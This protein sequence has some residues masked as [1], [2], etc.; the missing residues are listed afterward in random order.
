MTL[1]LVGLAGQSAAADFF[2]A[3]ALSEL[4]RIE[5]DIDYEGPEDTPVYG[6]VLRGLTFTQT[7]RFTWEEGRT[8]WGLPHDWEIL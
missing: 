7:A 5:G 1:W 8:G 3:P 4:I 6:V 2:V